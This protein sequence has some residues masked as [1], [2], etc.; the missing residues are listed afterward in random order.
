MNT[1]KKIALP[2]KLWIM[3]KSLYIT[4]KYSILS[5]YTAKTGKG[6]Q[7][8][9][10]VIHQWAKQLL[11]AVGVRYQ[12]IDLDDLQFQPGTPYIIMSNHASLYDIPLIFMTLPNR[13]IR[14]IAKKELFRVPLWGDAMRR[15]EFVAI[16]RQD[17]AQALK[18]L[19]V[20]KTNMENGIIPWIAPEGT[21]SRH[22]KLNPFKKGGFML[23][24][25]TGATII[26]V[27]IRGAGH[28][29]PPD[30][31]DF[32]YGQ[33]VEIYIGQPID[34]KQYTIRTRMALLA[35]VRQEIEKACG[36]VEETSQPP[37]ENTD[38]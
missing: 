7:A 20:V 38:A 3:V 16:D 35:A 26:P 33:T 13:S 9:D 1:G 15:S 6:R 28:I 29:L 10:E 25:Q 34:A 11:D 17:S 24:L 21:R 27:G 18:D 14:M 31:W 8:M 2:Q 5:I 12:V 36:E 23:A 37:T 32:H 30:T 19:Q 22:G 4:I